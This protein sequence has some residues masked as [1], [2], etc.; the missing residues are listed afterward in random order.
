[1]TEFEKA[2]LISKEMDRMRQEI[3]MNA[4]SMHRTFFVFITAF[5]GIAGVYFGKGIIDERHKAVFILLLSQVEILL[6][7]FLASLTCFQNVHAGYIRALE[8][9]LNEL[10]QDNISIWESKI[11]PKWM[12]RPS[13]A[14]FVT[15]SL[16]AL[17]YIVIFVILIYFTFEITD[18]ILWGVGFTLEVAACLGLLVWSLH[19]FEVVEHFAKGKLKERQQEK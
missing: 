19:V 13:S 12:V 4:R 2:Q 16:Q 7:L 8:H 1:M 14:F 6:C 5:V 17:A 11:V 15:C 3:I 9:K 10:A 18:H